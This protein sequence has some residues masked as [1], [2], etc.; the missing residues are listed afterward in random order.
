MIQMNSSISAYTDKHFTSGMTRQT[1]QDLLSD[2]GQVMKKS[3]R[4]ST[5]EK[6]AI[7]SPRSRPEPIDIP[8]MAGTV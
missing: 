6:S 7:I 1:R 4:R 5:S 2:F 8:R 3:A